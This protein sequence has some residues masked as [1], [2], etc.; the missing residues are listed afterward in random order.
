MI[1]VE[2][3]ADS[4]EDVVQYWCQLCETAADGVCQ[5]DGTD[6]IGGCDFR[7]YIKGALP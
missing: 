7:F 1:A 3:V 2:G 4:V 5:S 6:G